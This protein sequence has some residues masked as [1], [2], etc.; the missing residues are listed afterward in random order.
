MLQHLHDITKSYGKND[1]HWPKHF[2]ATT[3]SVSGAPLNPEY[4]CLPLLQDVTSQA[5]H[6]KQKCSLFYSYV[7]RGNDQIQHFCSI[8]V[9]QMWHI[10]GACFTF[11]NSACDVTT[12]LPSIPSEGGGAEASGPAPSGGLKID[13]KGIPLIIYYVNEHLKGKM[14][15]FLN[16]IVPWL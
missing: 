11:E 16:I 8:L 2:Q 10:K 3:T 1:L 6:I 9:S 13:T 7:D 5:G 12:P 15:H 4:C 14:K